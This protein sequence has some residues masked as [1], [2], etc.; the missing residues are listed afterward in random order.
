[1]PLSIEPIGI[2]AS[3]FFEKQLVKKR[4]IKKAQYILIGV[5]LIYVIVKSGTEKKEKKTLLMKPIFNV[6]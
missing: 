4:L 2:D 3:W 1:M 5:V 6:I